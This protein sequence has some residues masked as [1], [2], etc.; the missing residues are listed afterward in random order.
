MSLV[1]NKRTIKNPY[2]EPGTKKT[3]IWK[4]KKFLS[5]K[6]SVSDIFFK[7]SSVRNNSL[8]TVQTKRRNFSMNTDQNYYYGNSYWVGLWRHYVGSYFN[9]QKLDVESSLTKVEKDKN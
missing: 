2:I 3:F 7:K 6:F 5:G 1:K 4:L 9:Q 8:P